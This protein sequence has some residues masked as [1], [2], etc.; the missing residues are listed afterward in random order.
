MIDF[1]RQYG[2]VDARALW[3]WDSANLVAG[4]P[5]E[6]QD[7][8]RKG[9]ENFIGTPP[10]QQLGVTGAL[11]RNE[12]NE[13]STADVYAQGE[14]T[15][16]QSVSATLGVRS[17][18]VKLSSSDHFLS[19]GDDS[20]SSDF[21]YT[22]PVASL[23]WRARSDL[24][25][26]V[27]VGRGFESPTLNEVAYRPDGSSGFNEDLDAQ[28]SKQ[29]EV[30]AKW[31]SEAARLGADLAIFRAETEDEIAVRTNTGGRSTFANVGRTL[32]QGVEVSAQWR[33]VN[34]LRGLVA[35]TWLDAT[36]RDSFLTCTGTPCV[37]PTAVVPDG[38]KIAGTSPR[39]A[40][41]EAGLER[42]A[43]RRIR[44]RMARPGRD[45][46]QRPQQ[47]FRRGLWRVRGTGAL[48]PAAQR[49]WQRRRDLGTHRQPGRQG[50][51]R[52]RDRQRG[53]FA[54][55][56]AGRSARRAG[57]IT[58]EA[59]THP[60]SAFGAPPR[61][62]RVPRLQADLRRLGRH[63]RQPTLAAGS[64]CGPAKRL[65]FSEGSYRVSDVMPQLKPDPRLPLAGC[66][67]D[68]AGD[69]A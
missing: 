44:A 56:R 7:D 2:G 24:N 61:G 25:L 26:Y 21:D 57:G 49:R 62:G 29:I 69:I 42:N 30:G 58:L 41:A 18:R 33:P 46:G 4:A 34:T 55:L 64:A 10:N 6:Q 50:I 5:Y 39:S 54:L 63:E 9:F 59:V 48:D 32:R 37:T 22:N 31:R 43:A 27:S 17:G 67:F 14:V 45:R 65:R 68:A 35:L 36:Y 15:L 13:A 47:R 11:R 16:T 38:N 3:R 66:A 23:Q 53:Q 20:G 40:Y 60:R 19:N 52:Q 1:S 12:A 28:T 51:C 8:D